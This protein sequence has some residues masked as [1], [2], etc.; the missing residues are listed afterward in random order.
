[1]TIRLIR[2][3]NLSAEVA[4]PAS[5]SISN[6]ALLLA[7]LSGSP[8]SDL[9][10]ISDC[11]DTR[12]MLAAL[13]TDSTTIDIGAAGTAMRFL[14]AWL[15][16]GTCQY[17]RGSSEP[18]V[19]TGSARMCERPISVLVNALR[20]LGVQIEYL[21]NEG[22][23]PLR[24]TP[25]AL[26]GGRLSL[27]GDVSSQYVS[28]LLMIA[29]LLAEGLELTLTGAVASRPYIDMTL[30][31]M[32]HFGAEACWKDEQT[33]AVKPQPYR[34]EA[35]TIESDW[36]AASYWYSIVML[37]S[38]EHETATLKGLFDTSLQGDSEMRGLF[39]KLGVETIALSQGT[40]DPM[41]N[42]TRRPL[43]P[44]RVEYDF[45]G[46]P[47][48]VQ[49]LAVACAFKGVPFRFTGVQSLR[50]KET[51]RIAALQRE[52]DKLGVTLE[53]EGDEAIVWPGPGKQR[54]ASVGYLQ[55]AVGTSIDTYADHRMA[56]AFAPAAQVLGSIVI[57]NPEV[58]TKSYP[59]FWDDLVQAGFTI[60]NF[61]S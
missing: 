60:E 5:K 19:L 3:Y 55:P 51:D 32:S 23:P 28:A 13:T 57:N 41:I 37:S 58:V 4:L 22:F 9:T 43:Q 6:R 1:M 21:G 61:Q 45:T 20:E 14:T 47:D 26:R 16:L 18:R 56:M 12:A 48:I 39:R 10:N 50:I 38:N 54:M 8:V 33:I 34:Q 11:D 15:S 30:S 40:R 25:T 2:P 24:I 42:I 31:M 52:L 53:N 59:R 36:S 29:P 44:Q 7:A 17:E 49:T 46:M 35:Y 27:R